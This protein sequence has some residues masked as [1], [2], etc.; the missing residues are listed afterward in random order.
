MIRGRGSPASMHRRRGRHLAR[1]DR[2]MQVDAGDAVAVHF[3][4]RLPT[5]ISLISGYD[6]RH[7]DSRNID[8]RRAE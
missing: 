6:T 5:L 2:T 8:S 1:I 7:R 3:P 4:P